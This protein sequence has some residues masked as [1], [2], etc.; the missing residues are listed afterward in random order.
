V[1]TVEEAVTYRDC[2]Y[3]G[4]DYY[5]ENSGA[6]FFGR[7]VE[8]GQIITNLQAARLTLLHAESGVGKSSLLRAGVAWRLRQLAIE[9]QQAHSASV[10]IPVVFSSWKDDPVPVLVAEIRRA[11]KP[12]LPD[13]PDVTLPAS[14]DAAI[15]AAAD[16]TGA[17]LF[18]M[19]DQFE[20]Y[21]L[22]SA[23]EPVPEHFADQLARCINQAHLPANFLIS[24]REDAYAGLGDLFNGRIANVYGNYLHVDYLDRAAAEKAIREPIEVYNRQPGVGQRVE[25][26]DGLVQAVLDQVRAYDV[27]GAP[28]QESADAHGVY[29]V[30]TPLLQLVMTTIWDRER[31]Q[32]SPE[33]RLSTLQGLE[34]VGKVV[35]N[36]LGNALRALGSGE[37]ETAVDVFDHLVTPSGGKIAESVPDLAVRTGHTEEQVGRVL[38]KL[39][40]ARIVRPVPAPPGQDPRRFRRYE[41]FHDVL[42]PTINRTIAAREEQRR[43]RRLRR[44]IAL[45]VG[46]LLV[47][48]AVGLWVGTLYS[49]ANTDRQ[50]AQSRQLAAAADEDIATDPELSTLLALQALHVYDTSQAEAALRQALPDTQE[51]RELN[52]GTPV[53]S[54]AF[55]PANA[56]RVVS[57]GETGDSWIWNVTTGRRL[58]LLRP[59][60]GFAKN[61]T[62]DA[63][64]YNPAGTQV[65]VGYGA[66]TVVIFNAATGKQLRSARMSDSIINLGYAGASQLAV[67]TAKGAYLG[68]PGSVW[69]ALQQGTSSEYQYTY[70]VAADPI[71]SARF[72]IAGQNGPSV[73][74]LGSSHDAKCQA[75]TPS[76]AS[77]SDIG[78]SPNG[79]Y[80]VTSDGDGSVRLYNATTG[81]FI[82]LFQAGDADALSVQ[83]NPAGTFVAAGYSSGMARVWSVSSGLEVAELAGSGTSVNT[84]DFSASGGQIVTASN[85]GTTRVWRTLPTGLEDEFSASQTG[86]TPNPTYEAEYS[87]RGTQLVI[88]D[89]S[90]N[91]YVYTSGGRREL[92]LSGL[93]ARVESA[94]F[95]PKGTEIATTTGE[96]VDQW[97]D[98]SRLSFPLFAHDYIFLGTGI[99]ARQ[100]NF[101]PD[102]SRLVI[103]TSVDTAEVRSA[104]TGELLFTL[105]PHQNFTMSAAVFRPN[106][107]QIL[108]ADGGGQVQVWNAANGA[109]IRAFDRVG[110]AIEDLEFNRGGS[111]FVTAADSGYVTVWAAGSDQRIRTFQAC[112]SPTTASFSPDGTEIVVGCSDGTARVFSAATGSLLTAL[113]VAGGGVVNTA[114]FSPSGRDIITTFG[115]S[116]S[117]GIAIWSSQLATS[118]VKQLEKFAQEQVDS[119]LTPAER[120][121]YL[122]SVNGP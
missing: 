99:Y 109:K 31:A 68:T 30:A 115:A 48:S 12:F 105:D 106:G 101:S 44:L 58:V 45:A 32:G 90:G 110:P 56:A 13:G 42:A 82:R 73:C 10:D 46:L 50:V 36:H 116:G 120:A 97:E 98:N 2:P 95:S 78:F 5:D 118:S 104:S 17:S 29:R 4:L 54:A 37:R 117:G 1:T 43:T 85:D 83:F 112:P 53:H 87:S 72:A 94:R 52:N 74:E 122:N 92:E 35:D 62:A 102:G 27:D 20:E 113:T 59:A 24:I 111:Q 93:G 16:A 57:G 84:V 14:L 75:L 77:V 69:Q 81:T 41:I 55:D 3:F 71:N 22:Y 6:W 40:R 108:T 38:E 49:A 89:D 79:R 47:V 91:A 26:Q 63:V 76:A 9:G 15:E 88:M 34:G 25:I 39:D 86:S 61:G 121:S 11:I 107:R 18:V 114:E 51:L 70:G 21:F 19:L 60:G 65:A 8:R 96:Y 66:G 23:R 28:T 119:T 100:V 33:L 64:A 80:V 67:A 103:T 7:E